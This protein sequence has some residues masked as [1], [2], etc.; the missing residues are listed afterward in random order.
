MTLQKAFAVWIAIIVAMAAGA[1]RTNNDMITQQF[2]ASTPKIA[3]Y[4]ALRLPRIGKQSEV[5]PHSGFIIQ[6]MFVNETAIETSAG[7]ILKSSL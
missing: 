5:K 6:G 4:G 1:E 3:K 2:T 7:L